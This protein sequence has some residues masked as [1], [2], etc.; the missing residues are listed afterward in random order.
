MCADLSIR[1][2]L[3]SPTLTGG[4]NRGYADRL[5]VLS[6]ASLTTE[7][8]HPECSGAEQGTVDGMSINISTSDEQQELHTN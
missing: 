3:I 2:S 8:T 7:G 6:E 1:Q 4:F 5:I